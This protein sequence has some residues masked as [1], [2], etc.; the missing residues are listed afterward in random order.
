[1]R[2]EFRKRKSIKHDDKMP[3]VDRNNALT[4]T[5]FKKLAK[6][7]FNAALSTT[8]SCRYPCVS[9]TISKPLDSLDDKILSKPH[10]VPTER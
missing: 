5:S 8:T 7:A 2:K 4:I 3:D 10:S 1:M 9:C 6:N